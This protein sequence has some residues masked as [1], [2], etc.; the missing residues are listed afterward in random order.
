MASHTDGAQA[1][2]S[3]VGHV[4][5]I[6]SDL[7]RK[8]RV[9]LVGVVILALVTLLA[10]SWESRRRALDRDLFVAV[11]SED[12][13]EVARM[14]QLGADPNSRLDA[15]RFSWFSR[16]VLRL[17]GNPLWN[18]PRIDQSGSLLIYVDQKRRT[19]QSH[20]GRL[21]KP[22]R[23]DSLESSRTAKPRL[24]NLRASEARL[25]RIRELLVQYG[26]HR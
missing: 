10:G 16:I 25:G 22:N 12:P 5:L 9:A 1:P 11:Y 13:Q 17:Q 2:L 18:D 15:K 14:L 21:T 23:Y 19:A 8:A 6:R 26:A 4:S 24:A 20:I 3:A 7:L